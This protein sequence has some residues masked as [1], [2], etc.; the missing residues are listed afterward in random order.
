MSIITQLTVDEWEA[1]FRPLTNHLSDN[2]GWADEDGQG[3]LF[4]TYG[5]E[6]DFV[7][8]HNL[9]RMVWTYKDGDDGV[10]ITNG[11]SWANRIG[12]FVCQVPYDDDKFYE[13]KV[14]GD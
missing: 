7:C 12:Y 2:A 4:E 10:Y 9:K 5:N 6:H 13:V 3:I 14:S 1:Q 11:Y 8:K